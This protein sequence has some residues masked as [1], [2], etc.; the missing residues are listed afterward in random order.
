MYFIIALDLQTQMNKVRKMDM[1]VLK[2]KSTEKL[3]D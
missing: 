1:S 3:R 2:Q